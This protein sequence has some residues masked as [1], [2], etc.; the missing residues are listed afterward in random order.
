MVMGV[1]TAIIGVFMILYPFA[2]AA[3]TTIFFGWSLLIA[4][5][6]NLVFAFYAPSAG[7]FLVK[8]LLAILYGVAGVGVLLNPAAGVAALTLALGT[9]LV[10]QAG[11]EFSI[12]TLYRAEVSWGWM[13]LDSLVSLALGLMIL[14]HWPFSSVWAVGTMVGAGV[15]VAG[16]SRIVV[17]ATV[18]HGVG[19]LESL[20]NA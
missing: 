6:A 10:I 14:F 18:H 3:A 1:V 7:P 5:V 11:I 20:A 15:L 8:V 12:A 13:L 16:I 4:A 2:T 19:K 17:A 9:M